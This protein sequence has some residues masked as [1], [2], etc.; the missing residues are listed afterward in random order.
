MDKD[1]A[2]EVLGKILE[3]ARVPIAV[4]DSKG[5]VTLFNSAVEQLTGYSRADVVGLSVNLFYESLEIPR[6]IRELVLR[7]GS[8]EDFETTLLGKDGRRIPVS[9]VVTR[10][11]DSRGEPIGMLAIIVDLTERRRLEATLRDAVARA[12]FSNDLLT[13]DIRNYA[14][15]IGGYLETLLDGKLGDLPDPQLRLLSICRRQA[16]RIDGLIGNLQLLLKVAG[17]SEDSPAPL[18]MATPLVGVL[19]RALQDVRTLYSERRIETDVDVS[20]DV[21]VLACTHF[22]HVLH[23]LLINAVGHNPAETPHL[24]IRAAPIDLNGRAGWAIAVADNGPGVPLSMR[25]RLMDP[26]IRFDR[27]ESGVGLSVIK[28][29]VQRCGGRFRYEDRVAGDPGAG[30]RFLVDLP[31]AQPP[32]GDA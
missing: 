15:T 31:A 7:D 28:A 27:R 26:A 1:Q 13:H 10:L 8:V 24:W 11:V 18:L 22:P 29:L 16:Q 30:A 12:D 21:A 5:M 9:L 6:Q 19:D 4:A 17:C 32:G 2:V 25:E 14:Q 23:N 3:H 20:G